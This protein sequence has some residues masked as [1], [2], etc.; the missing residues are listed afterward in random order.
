MISADDNDGTVNYQKYDKCVSL[1]M[2]VEA[3]K[4]RGKQANAM[5]TSFLFHE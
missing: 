4:Q 3:I 2:Y 1:L 5:Q